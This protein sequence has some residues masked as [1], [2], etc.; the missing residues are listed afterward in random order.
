MG[1]DLYGERPTVKTGTVKPKEIDWDNATDDENDIYWKA[2]DK[3]RAENPGDYFRANVW[4]WRP[5]WN[6]TCEMCPDILTEEDLERGH[7]NDN[8]LIE[9]DRARDIAK[10]L[11]E[12]MDLAKERQKKYEAESPNKIKF[13]NMLEEAGDFLFK[14][15]SK[16][17]NKLISCPG[18]METYDPE[19][20][21]R[22]KSLLHSQGTKFDDTSYPVNAEWIEE[23]AN[24]AEHSGGFRIN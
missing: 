15:I 4:G 17:K 12:K 24:F 22:W 11:R 6:F 20:Y 19:N 13:N 9:E 3:F 21:K 23:F 7:Y 10:R 1:F 18:D 8:H 14:E 2:Q 5:I 16:P